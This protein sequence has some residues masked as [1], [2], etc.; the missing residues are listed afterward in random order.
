MKK[1]LGFAMAVGALL[2][3]YSCEEEVVNPGN[4][5][6]KSELT[7]DSVLTSIHGQRYI[8][9]EEAVFDTAYT[10]TYEKR[11]TTFKNNARSSCEQRY[12]PSY[13]LPSL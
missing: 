7:I 9:E 12:D 3:F 2:V 8:L 6:L 10:D 13:L 1:L 11:D 4:F 5:N